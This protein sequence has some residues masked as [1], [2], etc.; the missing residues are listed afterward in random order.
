VLRPINLGL[1]FFAFVL[2]LLIM[3][4][5]DRPD[6]RLVYL[7]LIYPIYYTVLSLYLHFRP[8][9]RSLVRFSGQRG[10]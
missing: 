8:R 4:D 2:I 6:P 10:G 3:R 1:G 5:F 7:S 9:F